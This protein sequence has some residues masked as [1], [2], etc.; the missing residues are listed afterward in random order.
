M[1]ST[2]PKTYLLLRAL[3]P[4]NPFSRFGGVA[5]CWNCKSVTRGVKVWWSCVRAI[6]KKVCETWGWVRHARSNSALS[7]YFR[8]LLAKEGII[9]KEDRHV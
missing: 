8:G 2:F 9:I 6:P 1:R 5:F 3:R 7:S 4:I